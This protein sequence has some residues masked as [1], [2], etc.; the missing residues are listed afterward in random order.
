VVLSSP[1]VAGEGALDPM[2][3]DQ[4]DLKKLRAFHLVVKF[5][6]LRRAAARL[7]LTVPAVSFSI[8]RLEKQLDLTLFQRLPNR[9]VLTPAGERVA[10]GVELIFQEISSVFTPIAFQSMPKGRLKMSVNSDLAWYFIPRI[11]AFIKANPDVEL[12]LDIRSS[13]EA[14]AEVQRGDVDLGIGRYS[15]VPKGI[16]RERIAE[17]SV[18]LACPRDHPLLRR[19]A[20]QIEDIARYKLVTLPSRNSTRRLINAAFSKAGVKTR[21]CIEAG[22]CQTVCSFVESGLGIG[23]IHSLCAGR[24]RKGQLR[25]IDLSHCFGTVEFSVVYRKGAPATPGFVRMLEVCTAR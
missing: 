14:L 10:Q 4:L 11:A 6:S 21:S 3:I 1:G 24:E 5:G 20:P 13:S 25:Y 12:G 18:S 9:M 7:N 15:K 23:L 2:N 19:N 22:T 16:E 8:R 17:S